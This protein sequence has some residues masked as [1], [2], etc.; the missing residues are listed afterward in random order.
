MNLIV[1]LLKPHWAVLMKAVSS[2]EFIRHLKIFQKSNTKKSSQINQEDLFGS[3]GSILSAFI[4]NPEFQ[5][6]TKEKLSSIEPGR[7]IEMKARQL[8]EQWLTKKT[9]SAEELFQYAFNRSQLRLQSK[10]NQIIEKNIKKKQPYQVN[11]LIVQLMEIKELKFFLLKETRLVD[12]QNKQ[13]IAK[14]RHFTFKG[15]ILNV[16]SAGRDKINANQEITDLMQAIGCKR[17]INLI[18]K[19]L[20]TKKL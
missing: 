9:R 6:Q 17:E 2:Q 20:D 7:K 8:F 14:H 3:S 10:S 11:L 1:T 18:A 15:K 16:I 13:E 5:G 4:E 12:R 19:I